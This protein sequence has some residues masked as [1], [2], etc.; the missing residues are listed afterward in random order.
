[1]PVYI[2]DLPTDQYGE[3]IIVIAKALNPQAAWGLVATERPDLLDRIK[4]TP[5]E[6]LYAS[7]GPTLLIYEAHQ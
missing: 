1:M 7:T 5:V 3:M 6:P 4:D 2:W